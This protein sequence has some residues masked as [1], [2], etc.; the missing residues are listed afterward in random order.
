MDFVIIPSILYTIKIA[1]LGFI[2]YLVNVS[3]SVNVKR[4][5]T[6]GTIFFTLESIRAHFFHHSMPT[7]C[8]LILIYFKGD[9]DSFLF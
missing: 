1:A 4:M 7:P 3:N 2:V 9:R 8:S 6:N 5:H